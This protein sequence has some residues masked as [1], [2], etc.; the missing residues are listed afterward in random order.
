MLLKERG[1][2]ED[3]LLKHDVEGRGILE[4]NIDYS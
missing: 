3:G 2:T 4:I 1:L